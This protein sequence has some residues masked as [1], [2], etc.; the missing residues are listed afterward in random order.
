MPPD[1]NSVSG[2]A[3]TTPS[4]SVQTG[5]GRGA[6]RYTASQQSIAAVQAALEQIR[7][8][9]ANPDRALE[10]Q[11][12]PLTGLVLVTIKDA[13]TGEPIRQIPGNALLTL[14]EMLTTR[15]PGPTALVDLTA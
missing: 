9:L 14:A 13:Q 11:S 15:D 4:A 8:N 12:D 5:S 6:K 3:A 2:I 10:F 7:E 1:L